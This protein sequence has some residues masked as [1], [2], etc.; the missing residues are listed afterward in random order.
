ML[1]Q[2]EQKNT[3]LVDKESKR[4]AKQISKFPNAINRVI[5]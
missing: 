5:L 2:S 1:T 4:K 3:S